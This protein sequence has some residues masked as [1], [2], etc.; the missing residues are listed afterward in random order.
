MKTIT[1]VVKDG[2]IVTSSP[3][4][5]KDNFAVAYNNEEHGQFMKLLK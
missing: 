4:V 2:E 3:N 1:T 5:N